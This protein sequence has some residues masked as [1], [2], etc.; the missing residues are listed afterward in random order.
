MA[1]LQDL[2]LPLPLLTKEGSKQKHK[3]PKD[4][5]FLY[6]AWIPDQ[7]GDKRRE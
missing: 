4:T 2:Y 7:V 6:I 5:R 3:D 1:R